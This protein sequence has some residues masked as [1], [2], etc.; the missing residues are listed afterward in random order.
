MNDSEGRTDLR[1]LLITLA[2]GVVLIYGLKAAQTIVVPFLLSVFLTVVGVPPLTWL[3]RKGVPN[4]LG[5]ALVVIGMVLVVVLMVSLIGTSVADFTS[6]IPYY[7]ERL[8]QQIA[9]LLDRLGL[10]DRIGS[11]R[12]LLATVDP[13]AAIDMVGGLLNSVSGIFNYT[14]LILFSVVFMLAEVASIPNKLEAAFSSSEETLRAFNRFNKSLNRY[15]GLKTAIGL[16]TGIAVTIWVMILGLDFPL[17]WGLVAFLFNYVPN[18][19]SI[20]A[21]IPA[22]L[23]AMV[24][25]GFGRAIMVAVGYL[26]INLLIGNLI[27]PRVLGKGLGLSTVVVFLSLV[28]WGWVLGPM[29]MLLSVPLTMTLVM[30]LESHEKTRGFAIL[31]G[32]ERHETASEAA[33]EGTPGEN[34][35]HAATD[36]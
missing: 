9:T 5:V 26:V 29:G 23:L 27:E 36:S 24:Q 30:A 15:I 8:D 2:A 19:G 20:I 16:I 10:G 6:R 7:Q 28:F 17:L 34:R 4:S 3:R 32:I 14:F 25:W 21:A 11:T 33:D 31:L 18:I 13:G 12:E 35:P 22:V 1:G